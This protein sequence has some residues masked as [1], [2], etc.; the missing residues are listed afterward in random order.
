MRLPIAGASA[1][2]TIRR[3]DF[4]NFNYPTSICAKEFGFGSTVSVHD[5]N[6]QEGSDLD[7]SYFGI[8]DHKIR[9]A[10][11]TGGGNEEAIV[12]IA[13]GH[14][15]YNWG[16][17]L[18]VLYKPD[19]TGGA[20]RVGDITSKLMENDYHRYYPDGD[21]HSITAVRPQGG[22]LFID[23]A[24]DG[25]RCC[26]KYIATLQYRWNGQQFVLAARPQKRAF[27]P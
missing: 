15:G 25:P 1:N 9:Y 10:N 24:A 19:S 23:W 2:K 18:I 16:F 14:T 12:H 17:D 6:Y 27:K 7:S 11:V 22:A 21:L 13:C 4:L 8:V 26:P 20:A 3:V 5:G